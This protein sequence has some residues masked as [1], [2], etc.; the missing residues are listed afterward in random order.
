MRL[1]VALALLAA[2]N[3]IGCA[4]AGWRANVAPEPA[5]AAEVVRRAELFRR[6]G[7]FAGA[8]RLYEKALEVDPR[9]VRAHAG[10]QVLG[11]LVGR[12]LELRRT[13]RSLGNAF[14]SGRLEGSLERQ[15]ESFARAREPWRSY[16]LASVA[17]AR[18][19]HA[20]AIGL[21]RDALAHDAGHSLARVGLGRALLAQG[22]LGEAAHQ[23]EAASWNDPQHPLPP[24]G[25]SVI[26]DRR[27]SFRE[28]YRWGVEGYRRAPSEA[29]LAA[30]MCSLA[31]R[32]GGA[33]LRR[34]AERLSRQRGEGAAESHLLAA[35][36]FGRS[37]DT[38]R[39]D[40]M[41]QVA[42]TLGVSA[43]EQ[44][45]VR[46]RPLGRELRAFVRAFARGTQARYRHYA[47]TGEAEQ[48]REFLAWAR[49]VYERETGRSLGPPGKPVAYALI[50]D[51]VDPTTGSDEPLVRAL[52]EDGMLLIIGRRRG[53][54]PEAMLADVVRR[55]RIHRRR[56]RGT[57]VV[58]EAVWTARRYLS[59]YLE[60][61]GG[62]DIAGLALSRIILV[63]LHAVARWEGGIRRRLRRVEPGR[64]AVLAEP[65]LQDEPRDGI[66]DPAGVAERLYLVSQRDLAEEVLVHE[67]AHLVDVARHLPIG[68]HPLRNLGL[69]LRRGFS[70]EEIQAFLE[71]NAQLAAIAEGP[72][73]RAA[74][75]VCCDQLGQRGAHA[76]GYAEIVEGFVD[77]LRDRPELY[78]EVDQERV[79]LQQLHRLPERKVRAIAIRLMRAWGVSES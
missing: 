33:Y 23:F 75:A 66:D 55:E 30:R 63:D 74:L 19:E 47:A 72:D 71:R 61:G 46:R 56:T 59:G 27:G 52:A 58:S 8:E 40:E 12:H 10:L 2:V 73:A 48:L 3:S 18:G 53:G 51:L 69:A 64:E 68:S 54:P 41:L 57:E 38:A 77:V 79:I 13:Y 36:L 16:G 5:P 42:D 4:G 9:D 70:A 35:D 44:E 20:R 31:G 6:Q 21:Y 15:E 78:P 37:G 1:G 43:A 26:A 60:W 11:T 17:A 14:L 45:T 28:A 34:A 24:L 7:D 32:A 62:G 29:S 65:A 39:R 49:S 25:L 50:G 76:S 67:V 22:K